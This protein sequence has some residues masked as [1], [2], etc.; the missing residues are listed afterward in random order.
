MKK[1]LVSLSIALSLL[2]VTAC[3][4]KE[5]TASY[6]ADSDALSLGNS[7]AYMVSQVV[8]QGMEESYAANVAAQGADPAPYANAFESW[9]RAKEDIGEFL[10]VG[11]LVSNTME[12]DVLGNMKKGII[13]VE[14]LGSDHD[15]VLE[16]MCERGEITSI[17]TNVR[18][19]FAENMKKAGLNTLLGMGTVFCVLILISLIISAFN[20]IPKIQNLGKKNKVSP[21]EQ[22]VEGAIAQII[23]QEEAADDTELVAVIAAAIA[24]SEGRTSTDGFVVRSIRK[25]ARR[26]A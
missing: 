9:K 14:I 25:R 1:L 7:A 24:A 12:V 21:T 8:D 19:S 23:E 3:S 18:Y 17:T 2:L 6:I 20:L 10:G 13:E 26:W 11:N 4:G 16:V 15:A 5:D 22:A